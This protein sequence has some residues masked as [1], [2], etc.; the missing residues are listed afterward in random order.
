MLTT[1]GTASISGYTKCKAALDVAIAELNGGEPLA[2][3]RMHDLRR[4]MASHMARFGVRLP[5]WSKS[6]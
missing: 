4:S 2:P 6:C 5:K 1:T 3:W